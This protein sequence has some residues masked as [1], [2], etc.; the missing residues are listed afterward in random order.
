MLTY[1]VSVSPLQDI[2][3]TTFRR[4]LGHYPSGVVGIT[5]RGSGGEPVGMAVSSFTSVSLDPPLVAFLPSKSSS[6]YAAIRDSGVFCANVLAADQEQ[7]CRA[8]AAK[9]GDKF[10]GVGWVAGAT[11]APLLEGAVAWVECTIEAVHDAGDHDIV[12]GRV[13]DLAVANSAVPLLFFQG[14]YGRFAP[15]SFSAG[16][17]PDLVEQLRL[18]DRLR[19]AMVRAATELRVEVLAT[20]LVEEEMVIIATSGHPDPGRVPSRVGQRMP[21]VP[22]LGAA[23]AAWSDPEAWLAKLGPDASA[24]TIGRHRIATERVRER[25]WSIGLGSAPHH[26]LEAALSRMSL[27]APT[28]LQCRAVEQALGEL[29]EE[30]EPEELRDGEL[31]SVRNLTVPV[32]G[33]DGDVVLVLAAYGL[34]SASTAADITTYRDVLTK[35]AESITGEKQ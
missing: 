23:F 22:P 5:S 10:A 26:G 15:L 34:P 1:D 16:S 7:V 25:G 3:S 31:Y 12:V 21:F 13:K 32:F 17:A 20:A 30:Y 35:A 29:S 11:G 27:D 8:F 4:V 9:G 24:E 14:G 28:A 33:A 6:T 19:P 2:D 18:V